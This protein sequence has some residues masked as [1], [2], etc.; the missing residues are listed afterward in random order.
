VA[1]LACV[2]SLGAAASAGA[3]AARV[4]AADSA[5]ART[6]P[7]RLLVYAQE[8]SLQPSRTTVPAGTVIVQLW[9][10]GMD[11]HDLRIRRHRPGGGDEAMYGKVL[12]AVKLT[13]PGKVSTATWTLKPGFYELYCSLPGHLAMGMHVDLRVTKG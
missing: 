4:V 12:G 7:A 3:A 5:H 9:N 2:G 6:Y 13:T 1:A 8:Y 10:R 11:P